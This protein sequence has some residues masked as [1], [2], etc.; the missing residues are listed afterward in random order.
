MKFRYLST[1]LGGGVLVTAVW[2]GIKRGQELGSKKSGLRYPPAYWEPTAE[3]LVALHKELPATLSGQRAPADAAE[4]VALAWMC[5]QPYQKRYAASARLYAEA[6]AAEPKVATYIGAHH[7]Y[8]AACSAALAAAGQGQDARALPDKVTTMFRRWA[9][10]WLRE[11]L[12][13]YAQ[14]VERNNRDRNKAIQRFL[15]HWRSDADLASVRDEAT[16]DRLPEGERDAWRALWR[17]V[18]ELAKRV[19]EKTQ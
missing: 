5:Q 11:D 10:R 4:A 7:R 1:V 16:L 15:A 9:I 3:R 18:D 6:F 12:S 13:S 17:D 14:V 2:I 8:N 19:A